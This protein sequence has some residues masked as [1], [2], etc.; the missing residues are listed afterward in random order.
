MRHTI[1]GSS[2]IRGPTLYIVE[3]LR[4]QE[5][6][7]DMARMLIPTM[8]YELAAWRKQDRLSDG[9]RDYFPTFHIISLFCALKLAA[10]HFVSVGKGY[11]GMD[12][13]M[14]R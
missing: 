11:A 7:W 9:W 3:P 14:D 2:R 5:Y 10:F 8:K 1:V 6:L 4:A 12:G 13:W